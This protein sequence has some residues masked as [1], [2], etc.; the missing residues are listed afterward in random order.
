MTTTEAVNT[1]GYVLEVYQDP[2]DSSWVAEVPDL[3]GCLAAGE[4]LA[5][6]LGLVEDAIDA[7][8]ES[9]NADGRAVPAPRPVED[10]YSGRFVLRISRTLHRRLASMAKREGI[11]LNAYCMAALAEGLGLA[12]ARELFVQTRAYPV[13]TTESY[14]LTVLGAER[15]AHR[16]P[17]RIAGY[18]TEGS[19]FSPLM[20]L[21]AAGAVEGRA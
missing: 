15:T 12:S 9:A 20:G 11:S 21:I 2:E 18:Q 16:V 5:E 17:E 7:W 14:S 6:A 19:S 1:R 10:E 3:P 8:I 4:T 13:A